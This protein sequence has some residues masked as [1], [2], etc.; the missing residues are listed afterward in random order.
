[1]KKSLLAFIITAFAVG[2]YAA[3]PKKPAPKIDCT[4]PAN[5]NKG[6]CQKAPES[7]V[8]PEIKKPEKQRAAPASVKKK[9]DENNAK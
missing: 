8:K 6:P 1:M 7:N 3:D 4:K 5:K 2:A 9:A